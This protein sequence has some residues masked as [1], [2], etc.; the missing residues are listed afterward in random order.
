[1]IKFYWPVVYVIC[2]IASISVIM[3]ALIVYTSHCDITTEPWKPYCY[4]HIENVKIN[5]FIWFPPMVILA[6]IVGYV[7][8]DERSEVEYVKR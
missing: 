4:R 6:F 7:Y 3:S 8:R 1:M 5:L 2:G